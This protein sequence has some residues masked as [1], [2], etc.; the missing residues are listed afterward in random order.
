MVFSVSDRSMLQ[1]LLMLLM[2]KM[3]KVLLIFSNQRSQL[4]KS[5]GIKR[6]SSMQEVYRTSFRRL[7]R[8]KPRE[9]V[10][11]CL[12]TELWKYPS[13]N[14]YHYLCHLAVPAWINKVPSKILCFRDVLTLNMKAFTTHFA[15]QPKCLSCA[16][17]NF[18]D[19]WATLTFLLVL[20]CF[21]WVMT[22]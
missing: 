13:Q 5:K 12:S 17:V 16:T 10:T 15:N 14:P 22:A 7:L 1:M 18:A 20:L 21:M 19:S 6:I 9:N 2:P 8:L 11:A 4:N 3:H